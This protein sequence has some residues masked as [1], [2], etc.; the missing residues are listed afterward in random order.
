MSTEQLNEYLE[1]EEFKQEC[2][3]GFKELDKDGSGFLD[4]TELRQC[5][6]ELAGAFPQDGASSVTVTD[7]DVDEAMKDL[8]TNHDN[9]ISLEE[10][11]VL[12]KIIFTAI[13]AGFAE[14]MAE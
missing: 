2:E 11:N 13:F 8:D 12:A 3:K 1:G 9:K 14:A 4:K 10:F 6:E 5:L 7:A